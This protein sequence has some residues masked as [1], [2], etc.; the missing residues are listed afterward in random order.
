MWRLDYVQ[1]M[2]ILRGDMNLQLIPRKT[3]ILELAL[4]LFCKRGQIST[5]GVCMPAQNYVP[6]TRHSRQNLVLQSGEV[7]LDIAR[8]MSN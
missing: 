6:A 2:L 4:E 7:S 3:D 5:L 8:L 1:R